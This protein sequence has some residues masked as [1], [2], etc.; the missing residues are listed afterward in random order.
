MICSDCI[1]RLTRLLSLISALNLSCAYS[2]KKLF[3]KILTLRRYIY[4]CNCLGNC[5][6]G[7]IRLAGGSS[8]LEGRVEVCFRGSWGTVCDDSWD[9]NDANVACRQLGYSETGQLDSFY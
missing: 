5:Q 1:W 2:S 8:Y 4:F 7:D 6:S 3:C 9:G